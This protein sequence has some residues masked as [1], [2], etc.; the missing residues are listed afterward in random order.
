M[1]TTRRGGGVRRRC[2]CRGADGK[3]RGAACPKLSSRSHGSHEIHQE[4]P[5]DANGKRRRF[6]RTGYPTVKEAQADLDRI[7]S[8]IDLAGDDEDDQRRVGDYLAAIAADR[9]PLPTVGEVERKLGVGVV[10]DGRM[11]VGQWLDTWLARKKTRKTT[12]NGYA[13]HIRVH[14]KPRIGHLRLD[15]LNAEHL[16]DMFDAILDDAQTVAAENQ[17]RREQAARSKWT[18]PGRP[19]AHERA[20][21]ELERAKL[22]AMPPYRKVTGP[23][24]LHA[25]RR[26]LNAALRRAVKQQL[27]TY[28]A[29]ESVELAARRRSK[30]MLW[31]EER[32]ARWRETGEKPG[33]VMVW[34]P[35]QLGA[36]LDHAEGHRLYAAYHLTALHGL[37]R[38]ECCGQ[39]WEHF[40]PQRRR[41]RVVREIVVD[42]YTMLQTDPK[43]EGSAAEIQ[44]DTGTVDVLQAHRA[45]QL[46]ERDAWNA[47]AAE[48]RAAGEDVADWVDTGNMFTAEDG[49]WLHPDVLSREFD[50]LVAEA[51]LPPINLRDLRHVAAALVK[52]GGG[53]IHDAKVKLRHDT[54][55]LTSD[56]YMELFQ[57]YEEDLAERSA[58][59]VP[60]ARK[61]SGQ[62]A[63]V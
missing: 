26:T 25:I 39:E 59:A 46:A 51:G 41:I 54:I 36:F 40:S 4:L 45:R 22:A 20:R 23:A 52:A 62:G 61:A 9:T 43:T 38:A 27:I 18:K 1:S 31:T 21:L 13:S 35:E 15:R 24:S 6:R 10:L 3:R 12:T 56:T 11:T 60:R 29:A 5:P 55:A 37:R 57:E 47:R 7:R 58:A 2:E 53:D 30:G 33:L 49:R 8:I 42:G 48:Q 63:E 17:A 34:T 19:P 28:N 50:R 14:L 32:I 44:L 16:A